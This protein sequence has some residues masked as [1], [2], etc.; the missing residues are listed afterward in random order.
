MQTGTRAI[1]PSLPAI[2]RIASA[3]GRARRLAFLAL[4]AAAVTGCAWLKPPPVADAAPT[5][6][7]QL[8]EQRNAQKKAGIAAAQPRAVPAQAA[9]DVDRISQ[10]LAGNADPSIAPGCDARDVAPHTDAHATW[11]DTLQDLQRRKACAS[12]RGAPR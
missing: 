9:L 7:G 4:V 2:N 10:K 6:T 12:G 11:G 3:T 1:G 8:A 5:Q